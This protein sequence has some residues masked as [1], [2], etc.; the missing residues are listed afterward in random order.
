[1][2]FAN[3][4]AEYGDQLGKELIADQVIERIKGV[5]SSFFSHISEALGRPQDEVPGS[6][7]D[8]GATVQKEVFRRF[9]ELHIKD[10]KLPTKAEVRK[11]CQLGNAAKD[12]SSA[13]EKV[14][15]AYK[16]LGLSGLPEGRGSG[17]KRYAAALKA[18]LLIFV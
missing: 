7:G 16:A 17:A 14:R 12:A 5:D 2:R 10:G 8:I 15:R 4:V 6:H 11:A 9:C 3:E 1:M 13:G 18:L